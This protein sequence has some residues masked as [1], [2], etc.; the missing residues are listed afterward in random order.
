VQAEGV[1]PEP[2]GQLGA[3][4]PLKVH[5][6]PEAW[7]DVVLLPEQAPA[8]GSQVLLSVLQVHPV[9]PWQPVLV[10]WREQLDVHPP[11]QK[12]PAVVQAVPVSVVHVPA[13]APTQPFPPAEPA[14]KRQFAAV[15]PAPPLLCSALWHAAVVEPTHPLP[16]ELPPL[17]E[18]A[19]LQEAWV[20]TAFAGQLAVI[21]QEPVHEHAELAAAHE[22]ASTPAPEGHV[23]A[24]HEP[25]H[26][27][28]GSPPAARVVHWLWVTPPP[29]TGH[30]FV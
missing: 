23:G 5:V 15:H 7:H 10:P 3:L 27:H 26:E 17:K 25:V 16:G 13:L 20:A 9:T 8:V 12:H 29:V 6:E 22:P 19:P 28:C 18:H 4:H 2:V 14:S 24:V 21:E 1:T 11:P 30:A